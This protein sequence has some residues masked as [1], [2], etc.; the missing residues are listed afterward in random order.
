MQFSSGLRVI[1]AQPALRKAISAVSAGFGSPPCFRPF[2]RR[3]ACEKAAEIV[4]GI[5]TAMI[6]EK[7]VQN[8]RKIGGYS[9][10]SQRIPLC[11]TLWISC[12]ER[13]ENGWKSNETDSS[14]HNSQLVENR[15]VTLD[16]VF[17]D[18]CT[19]TSCGPPLTS[20]R[21]KRTL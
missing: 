7:A 6:D 1:P 16:F 12:G 19:T 15:I 20:L 9:E 14:G 17:S 4:D 3:N 5:S 18:L 13:V 11:K 8:V 2:F 10:E 21:A